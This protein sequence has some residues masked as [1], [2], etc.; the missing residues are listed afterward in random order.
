MNTTVALDIMRLLRKEFVAEKLDGTLEA[1][2][3]VDVLTLAQSAAAILEATSNFVQDSAA[4]KLRVR[5][6][7]LE[8]QN[9]NLRENNRVLRRQLEDKDPH[10][11]VG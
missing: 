2:S 6:S 8:A 9:E 4:E 3:L 5:I 7:D 1:M 11:G 10:P